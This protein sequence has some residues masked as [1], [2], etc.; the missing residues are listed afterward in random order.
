MTETKICAR[1]K[2]ELP[3]DSFSRNRAR[4]DGRQAYCRDCYNRYNRQQREQGAKDSKP[5][6]ARRDPR[7]HA[8]LLSFLI[9][10]DEALERGLV[11]HKAQLFG[12]YL[13]AWGGSYFSDKG[14]NA[15]LGQPGKLYCPGCGKARPR[16]MFGMKDGKRAMNCSV[17]QLQEIGRARRKRKAGRLEVSA[18]KGKSGGGSGATADHDLRDVSAERYSSAAEG[19][20]TIPD[21]R[22]HQGRQAAGSAGR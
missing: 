22:Y 21:S 19:A 7:L 18:Q 11:S 12:A 16:E 15:E 3:M 10:A 17:C 9:A 2:Q 4:A 13:S 14:I 8:F 6:S 20:Y 1:C 5:R